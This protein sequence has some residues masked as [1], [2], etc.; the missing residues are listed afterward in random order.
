M[1][2]SVLVTICILA[3]SG[4]VYARKDLPRKRRSLN[5][6]DELREIMA[7]HDVMRAENLER[8]EELREEIGLLD[9]QIATLRAEHQCVYTA[10]ASPCQ[11]PETVGYELSD[12]EELFAG[13]RTCKESKSS[14][15]SNICYCLHL[16]TLQFENA[17]RQALSAPSVRR[18]INRKRLLANELMHDET[19]ART[20]VPRLRDYMEQLRREYGP[21]NRALDILRVAFLLLFVDNRDASKEGGEEEEEEE[22]EDEDAG[23]R[24]SPSCPPPPPPPPGGAGH[25]I[26]VC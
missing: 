10:V 6:N 13:V 16:S 25:G 22:E 5:A 24:Q 4:I 21:G 23:K 26:S 14:H 18:K 12:D 8:Q 17:T 11:S 1:N 3:T 15:L 7:R 9:D 19:L 20:D 2:Y